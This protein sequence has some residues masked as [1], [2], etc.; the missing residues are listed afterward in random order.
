MTYH[1]AIHFC[2][3]R[4]REGLGCAQCLDNELFCVI[5]DLQG[6]KRGDGHLDY[7]VYIGNCFT[8]DYNLRIHVFRVPS[9]CRPTSKLR[10]GRF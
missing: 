3:E 8:S 7:L 4:Y 9:S 10:G 5:A 1:M 6:L 2:D